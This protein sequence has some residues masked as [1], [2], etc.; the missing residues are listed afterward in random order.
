MCRKGLKLG[1]GGLAVAMIAGFFVFG[2]DLNSYVSTSASNV[3]QSVKETVPIEFELQRARDMIDRIVPELQS[4]VRLIAQEEVEIA[5]L[6]KEI[7]HTRE[8][9]DRQRA[10][11]VD[12]R[13][14]LETQTVSY[15]VGSQDLSRQ[16][17]TERLA[18]RFSRLKETEIALDG[19]TRLLEARQKSLRAAQDMLDRAR[20]QKLELEQKVEGLVAQHRLIQASENASAL[21][22][23]GRQLSKADR[24]LADIQTRLDVAQRVLS[25]ESVLFDDDAIPLQWDEAALL[26]EVNEHLRGSAE[27]L[28]HV[29]ES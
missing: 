15:H 10:Q 1:L 27:S 24:L 18:S 5:A 22:V 7:S 16:Q 20:E 26:E 9:A 29:D 8:S 6:E 4:N 11:V 14:Q 23:D 19:K 21:R 28:V 3:R 25:H 12:L 13:D 2:R 17:A